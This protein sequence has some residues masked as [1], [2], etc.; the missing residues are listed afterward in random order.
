MVRQQCL[1]ISGF[2]GSHCQCVPT[3]FIF[4]L[5]LPPK[6]LSLCYILTFVVSLNNVSQDLTAP[7]YLDA[8]IHSHGDHDIYLLLLLS[9]GFGGVEPYLL[10][11][12]SYAWRLKFSKERLANITMIPVITLIIDCA[13]PL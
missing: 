2:V 5:S 12:V 10:L 11:S 13:V 8:E 7:N 6:R 4:N 3:L 9:Q 1:T